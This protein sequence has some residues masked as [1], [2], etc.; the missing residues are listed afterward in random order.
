MGE[1]VKMRKAMYVLKCL[2][3]LAVVEGLNASSIL[4]H[5]ASAKG[6]VNWLAPEIRC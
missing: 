1:P 6:D 2:L 3:W 5:A 4:C